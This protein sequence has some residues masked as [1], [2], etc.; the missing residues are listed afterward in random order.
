MKDLAAVALRDASV[1][2]QSALVGFVFF[3]LQK[4]NR[5]LN[6]AKL[7]LLLQDLTDLTNTSFEIGL[8]G[9]LPK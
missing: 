5:S 3:P 8:R 4:E 2:P 6:G 7:R 1:A 9:D